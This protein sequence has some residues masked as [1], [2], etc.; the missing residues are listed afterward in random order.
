MQQAAAAASRAACSAQF[1][2]LPA[3]RR[4]HMT[5][6]VSLALDK[7]GY[8]DGGAAGDEEGAHMWMPPQLVGAGGAGE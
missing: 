2:S 8:V 7:L 3:A 5:D 1:L 6:W 4:S